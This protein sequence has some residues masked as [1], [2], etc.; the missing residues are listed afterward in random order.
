[1][2]RP[3]AHEHTMKPNGYPAGLS[4]TLL[5]HSYMKQGIETNISSGTSLYRARHGA[6]YGLRV[7]TVPPRMG[8][9]NRARLTMLC[10]MPFA[11]P[12][13]WGGDTGKT[14]RWAH[15]PACQHRYAVL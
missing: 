4:W 9:A 10:A 1:M 11:K 2:A 7:R 13:R 14:V 6:G 8:P 5:D 15:E 12:T 3:Q